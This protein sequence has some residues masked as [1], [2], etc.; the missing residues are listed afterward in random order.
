MVS[1]LHHRGNPASQ[2][3][4]DSDDF[5]LYLREIASVPL[6]TKEREAELAARARAGDDEAKRQL[7]EANLRLVVSIAKPLARRSGID[8]RDL[9]QEGYFGLLRAI[10]KYDPGRGGRFS[11]YATWW[12]RQ[13]ISRAI[14][15]SLRIVRIPIYIWERLHR[16]RR[17]REQLE[18]T[19]GRDPDTAELAAAA[20]YSV[21]DIELLLFWSGDLAS[22]DVPLDESSDDHA[23]TLADVVPAETADFGDLLSSS[24][25]RAQIELAIDTVCSPR[26]ATVVR[27]RYGFEG[28]GE[29]MTLEQCGRIL[30]I[31]RERVRQI[32]VTACRKLY[33]PLRHIQR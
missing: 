4:G 33:T 13:C 5:K 14:P 28:Y 29:G 32:E 7:I 9:V 25:L 20:G 17:V 24:D 26:E 15:E 8:I 21:K 30:G 22:L 16:L 6:L 2:L 1:A 10:E 27:M 18:Q 12:I 19:L 3:P 31:T 23:L 11:T